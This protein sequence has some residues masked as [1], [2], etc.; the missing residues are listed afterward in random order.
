MAYSKVILN[1]TTL[2]DVTNDTV[3]ADN[4]LSGETATKNNGLRT[5]GTVVVPTKTSDLTNDSGFITASQAPVQSVNGNTGAVTISVPTKTSDLTNDSGFITSAQAPVQSVNG[6]TGAVTVQATLV[7]GTNIKTVN[8]ES[9]LGSGNITI[10]GGGGGTA[11]TDQEIE[12]A[13]DDAFKSV[14]IYLTNPSNPSDFSSFKVY[15]VSQEYDNYWDADANKGAEI[16]SI[17]SPTGS[18]EFTWDSS[19]YGIVTIA[20]GAYVG[21]GSVNTTG[22]ATLIDS[23]SEGGEFFSITGESTI[24]IDGIDYDD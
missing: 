21:S 12:D 7:S 24:I 3:D 1:G 9:L 13:V 4:L 14:T 19:N 15:I 10:Q 5:T 8:N 18:V 6:Q 2:M 22:G 17:D 16:A 23:N 20:T 11:L